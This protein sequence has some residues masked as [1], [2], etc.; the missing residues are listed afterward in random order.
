MRFPN[1]PSIGRVLEKSSILPPR[2]LINT[3]D[4]CIRKSSKLRQRLRG[5]L[6]QPKARTLTSSTAQ[7]LAQGT[8]TKPNHPEPIA[9]DKTIIKN[10]AGQLR[11]IP[12]PG[13]SISSSIHNNAKCLDSG[14]TFSGRSSSIAASQLIE[15]QSPS[16]E[17]KQLAPQRS[18]SDFDQ[19]LVKTDGSSR[20]RSLDPPFQPSQSTLENGPMSLEREHSA[21]DLSTLKY[22]LNADSLQALNRG[23][24]KKDG[25]IIC[26]MCILMPNDRNGSKA[27]KCFGIFDTGSPVCVTWLKV[28]DEIGY[29]SFIQR[30]TDNTP[31]QSASG[32]NMTVAG[33]IILSWKVA[34]SDERYVTTFIVLDDDRDPPA[35][36]ILGCDWMNES[37]ALIINHEKLYQVSLIL[38]DRDSVRTSQI[39]IPH[40]PGAPDG[41]TCA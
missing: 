40:P 11:T 36:F 15:S 30:R 22:R 39:I 31:L 16:S 9:D 33:K 12:I 1:H 23:E 4:W 17:T 2:V 35:D 20:S 25:K 5:N 41:L 3:R 26:D 29:T 6:I 13:R 14:T 32:H 38:V 21:P 7:S 8:S 28:I 37:E 19:S 34:M 24:E 10:S 27:L 18:G